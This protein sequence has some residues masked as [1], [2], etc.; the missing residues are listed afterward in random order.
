MSLLVCSLRGRTAAAFRFSEAD[1]SITHGWASR[2]G[3]DS[4]Y[5]TARSLFFDGAMHSNFSCTN[6]QQSLRAKIGYGSVS[7]TWGFFDVGVRLRHISRLSK[8]RKPSALNPIVNTNSLCST[9]QDDILNEFRLPEYEYL[10]R[11]SRQLPRSPAIYT[12]I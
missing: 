2:L 1:L 5:S 9:D 12:I 6:R 4:Q 8:N 10:G 7:A 11:P 3:L